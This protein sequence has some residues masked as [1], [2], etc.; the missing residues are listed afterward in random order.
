MAAC[1]ETNMQREQG[2][3]VYYEQGVSFNYL[4]IGK[5]YP[6]YWVL[7]SY[8]RCAVLSQCGLTQAGKY[9]PETK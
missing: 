2:Y 6:R 1:A 5:L 3:I 8:S 7:I 9:Q 4:G